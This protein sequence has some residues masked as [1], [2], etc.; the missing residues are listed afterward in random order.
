MYDAI[1]FRRDHPGIAL[2]GSVSNS[3]VHSYPAS[4]GCVRV[5][6]PDI[7]QIFLETPIG[8]R[9]VVYGAY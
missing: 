3:L 6:R 4:H 2:H 5:W 8:T 7:H 1:Y 9:V